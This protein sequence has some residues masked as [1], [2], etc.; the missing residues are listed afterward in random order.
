MKIKLIFDDWKLKGKSVYSTPAGAELSNGDFH[1]GTTFAGEI[2][3][4]DEQT[5]ELRLALMA[6]FR[7]CFWVTLPPVTNYPITP[8]VRRRDTALEHPGETHTHNPASD[9]DRPATG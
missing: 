4:T 3:L 9:D 5:Y 1:S 7:P 8:S 2:E 6:G